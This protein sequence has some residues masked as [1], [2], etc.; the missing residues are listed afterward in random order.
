MGFSFA[1]N[2]ALEPLSDGADTFA[3]PSEIAFLERDVPLQI[4]K[5][6]ACAAERIGV[7]AER[8]LLAEGLMS[9]ET[10]YRA[11]A[12]SLDLPYAERPVRPAPDAAIIRILDSGLMP[13]VPNAQGWRFLAAPR[14]AIL[15]RFLL[16]VQSCSPQQMPSVALTSPERLEALLRHDQRHA[17][18][19][20]ATHGLPDWDRTLSAKVGITPA[21]AFAICVAAL[22]FCVTAWL[23]ATAASLAIMGLFVG[24]FL[25]AIILRL[26]ATAAS[27]GGSSRATERVQDRDL[28]VYSVIVPLFREAR[29]VKR[30]VSALDRL[31]YP[32]AKLD[33]LLVVEASDRGT[34]DAIDSLRLPARYRTVVAPPGRPRTK[35][36]ALNI[37]LQFARGRYVVIFD[38]ED[39]PEPNQLRAAVGAF[40]ADPS[41][42]CVQA[43]LAIDN[44]GDGWLATLFAIEYAALFHVVNP[45]LAALDLPIPLG[46]TSNHFVVEVLRR[47]NGWDAWNVTEDI[48]LGI[49]LARFGQRVRSLDSTTFEEAPNTVDAWLKQRRR[50]MKGWM[51]TV[52]THS[53][54][55]AR[56]WREL[57]TRKTLAVLAMLFGTI[58][59]SLLGPFC[60]AM[61]LVRALTGN[62]FWTR[63]TWDYWC[64]AASAAL[65][66]LGLVAIVWPAVLGLKRRGL[67]GL[68]KSLV[69]YPAYIVLLSIASWQALFEVFGRPHVWAKTEHGRAKQRVNSIPTS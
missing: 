36:R 23:S 37:A 9:S 68:A 8:I 63:S 41:T 54:A 39:E 51:V 43:R 6:A 24:G 17:V 13:L 61:V 3:L 18:V 65:L 50:W 4:L 60:F 66:G 57:G 11:L 42:A 1:P 45:G 16:L 49:R 67:P 14:G 25:S 12:R 64:T 47:I 22:A 10:Y 15:R 34:L 48:D 56:L 21:Q 69:L 2:M 31:D 44:A 40:A 30:L 19:R 7:T 55:P 28:P 20:S 53:R 46:G 38:A 33:I 35:P 32:R 58:L 59:S 26:V 62:L 52:G 5:E 27:P 29:V